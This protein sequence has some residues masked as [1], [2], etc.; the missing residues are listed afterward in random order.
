MRRETVLVLKAKLAPSVVTTKA[1][2]GAHYLRCVL[3]SQG[4]T[5][6]LMLLLQPIS[7][8]GRCFHCM[9]VLTNRMMPASAAQF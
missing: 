1:C 5:V 4:H 9:P 7:T 2:C 3:S 8:R 6:R